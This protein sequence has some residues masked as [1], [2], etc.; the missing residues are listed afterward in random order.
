MS[1]LKVIVIVS[2]IFIVLIYSVVAII[3]RI[4]VYGDIAEINQLRLDA[5]KVN[6]LESEDVRGQVVEIN[7]VIVKKKM[8]NNIWWSAFIIPNAWD[9]VEIIE[10]KQVLTNE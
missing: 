4:K 6:A 8:Y 9:K 10:I 5:S 1:D 7:R 2:V 3:E